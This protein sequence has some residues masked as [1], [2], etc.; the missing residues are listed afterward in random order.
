MCCYQWCYTSLSVL[1][2]SINWEFQWTLPKSCSS[3]NFMII[4][5][6]LSLSC[7][8]PLCPGATASRNGRFARAQLAHVGLRTVVCF[9]FSSVFPHWPALIKWTQDTSTHLLCLPC[10]CFFGVRTDVLHVHIPCLET[11]NKTLITKEEDNHWIHMKRECV[12]F[13]WLICWSV[14]LL[15]P[16]PEDGCF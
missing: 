16:G 5:D 11:A 10:K 15:K 14:N 3:C 6:C 9:G 4:V 2:H 1:R 12:L 7:P 8:Q 13:V